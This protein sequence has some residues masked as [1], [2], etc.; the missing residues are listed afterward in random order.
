[1]L[2]FPCNNSG[3][4]GHG[5]ANPVRP[6]GALLS[7]FGT[8][9]VANDTLV[10]AGDF[11]TNSAVTYFQGTGVSNGIVFGDGLVCANG[12]VIRLGVRQAS[13]GAS[14]YPGP[15]GIPVSVRGQ[16]PASG[17]ARYYQIWYRVAATFCTPATWS[18]SNA[19]RIDWTI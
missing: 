10:L 1:V 2:V 16:V 9:S 18:F 11:T 7:V 12:V 8:P 14:R 4:P 19:Y 13:S 5:C 15:G 17:G 6:E 3:A